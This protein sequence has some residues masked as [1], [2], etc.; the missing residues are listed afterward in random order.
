MNHPFGMIQPERTWESDKYRYGFNSQEM[1]N[2]VSGIGNSYT[3]EYWQYDSRLGRRWNIDPKPNPSI[4]HYATFANNPILYNDFK[5]DTTRVFD[6]TGKYAFTINDNLPN[7]VHFMDPEAAFQIIQDNPDFS[8]NEWATKLREQSTAF[9]GTNSISD[10]QNILSD[11]LND[12]LESGF[13]AEISK[14]RELRFKQIHTNDRDFN[15][16]NLIAAVQLKFSSEQQSK[17]FAAGHTHV[18]SFWTR[19]VGGDRNYKLSYFGE[20]TKDDYQ[21]VLNRGTRRAHPLIIGS[22]FGITIYQI[23]KQERDKK[24]LIDYNFFK[25]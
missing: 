4:S 18:I 12:G 6:H 11:P 3:A 23:T 13:V 9:I 21:P 1:D 25:K 15:R 19:N 2:E 17:L 5:G 16:V 24:S 14:S 7:Q 20:P 8:T 10:L 22:N